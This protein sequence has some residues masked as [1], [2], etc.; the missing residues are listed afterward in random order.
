MVSFP[1]IG[2]QQGMQLSGGGGGQEK[3]SFCFAMLNLTCLL[4]GGK[5]G[6]GRELDRWIWSLRSRL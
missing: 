5:G 4:D 3:K 6:V 1:R 2:R